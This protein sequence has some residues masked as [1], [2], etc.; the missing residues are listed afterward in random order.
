MDQDEQRHLEELRKVLTRRLRV[1]ELQA[2][3][4]GAIPP[5]DMVME[6]EDLR[7]RIVEV[8]EQLSTVELPP[9]NAGVNS[10][11]KLL[12]VVFSIDLPEWNPNLQEAMLGAL[13]TVMDTPLDRIKIMSIKPGSI[14]IVLRVP[15]DAATRLL[16][17]YRLRHPVIH[18][19]YIENIGVPITEFLIGSDSIFPL[20]ILPPYSLLAHELTHVVQQKRDAPNK[21]FPDTALL[22]SIKNEID[23]YSQ[24][25]Q[26]K[27][28]RVQSEDKDQDDDLIQIEKQLQMLRQRYGDLEME[29]LAWVIATQ[30]Q[31]AGILLETLERSPEKLQEQIKQ[32]LKRLEE[33]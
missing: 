13:A 19:L 17:L 21:D 28:N 11:E 31:E 8:G 1:L 33:D 12:Q 7:R 2:A 24:M 23:T 5:P 16:D 3:R 14:K 9:D 27:Q 29:A 10:P 15:E 32:H 18:D 4:L 20:P 25:L 6:I 22:H 26:K 30:A